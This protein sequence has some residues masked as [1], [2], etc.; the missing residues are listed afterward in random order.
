M[1][2]NQCMTCIR[3]FRSSRR[4]SL[5]GAFLIV[6]LFPLSAGAFDIL[7]GTGEDGTF[8]HFAGRMLCRVIN[9]QS[10]DIK[11]KPVPAPDAMHNLTNL[12]GGSL[13]ISLVDSRMLHDA[14]NKKGYF[15]FLDIRYENL[16]TLVPIYDDPITL[17]ARGDADIAS[18]GDLK[19][20]RIN[21]GA[22]RSPQHLA[23][24]T[25]MKAKNWTEDDFRL[26]GELP[27]SQ[28]QD[29][30]A[31]CH[32]EVQ[33]MLHIGVH[34][35]SSVKQ[36]IKLCKAD[37]VDMND[38]D[39]QKLV[40]GHPAFKTMTIA[41]GVY[42]SRPESVATFGTTAMLVASEDLDEETV[43][44]ILDAI[45]THRKSM[46]RAHPALSAFTTE[47]ARKSDVAIQPH[48]GAAKY[49]SE[50]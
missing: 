5:I 11:C 19:G 31:F 49:F 29:T 35:N 41:A 16:R 50:H 6:A 24:E 4:V 14:M 17:V 12:R 37:L 23:V 1:T 27:A 15:E 3:F 21:A 30:M 20:K 32:G 2:T 34:P 7:L 38:A 46:M 48:P 9:S 13:D 33:A 42:P 36:L 10:K 26:F 28:S 45:Y 47:A 18:V 25:I 8:S 39:I 43:Y 40:D 44:T 22:P